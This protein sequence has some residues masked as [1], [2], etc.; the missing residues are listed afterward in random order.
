MDLQRDWRVTFEMMALL[1]LFFVLCSFVA[2]GE[3]LI[4]LLCTSSLEE[5]FLKIIKVNREY[6]HNT[7]KFGVWTYD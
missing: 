5:F 2:L 7:D 6:V 1:L 4:V 3:P